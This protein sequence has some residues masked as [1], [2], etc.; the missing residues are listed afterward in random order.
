MEINLDLSKM[1]DSIKPC[2]ILKKWWGITNG[3]SIIKLI[4]L[5]SGLL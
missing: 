2:I 3:L 5:K 1:I 4:L